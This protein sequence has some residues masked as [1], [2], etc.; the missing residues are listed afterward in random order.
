MKKVDL[1]ILLQVAG[2]V[3]LVTSILALQGVM[4]GIGL[5]IAGMLI[6]GPNV[7]QIKGKTGGIVYVSGKTGPYTR[8]RVKARNPNT[9]VHSRR[10]DRCTG[11]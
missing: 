2:I 6:F 5:G 11:V 1:K 3:L 9:T 4:A 7:E 8:A 10:T